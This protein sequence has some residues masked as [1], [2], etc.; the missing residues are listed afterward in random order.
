MTKVSQRQP[1]GALDLCIML[2]TLIVALIHICLW[3]YPAEPLRVWF[4]LNGYGAIAL[5]IVFYAQFLS[6]YRRLSGCALISYTAVTMTLYCLLGRP[7]T[8]L[9][10]VTLGLEAVLIALIIMKILR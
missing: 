1:I 5:L 2:L 8:L 9:G 6:A 7:Y 10:M 4:L 3:S